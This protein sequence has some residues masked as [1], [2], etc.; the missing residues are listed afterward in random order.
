MT[1]LCPAWGGGTVGFR[2]GRRA[3]LWRPRAQEAPRADLSQ[4]S[5]SGARYHALAPYRDQAIL[6][7]HALHQSARFERGWKLLSGTYKRTVVIPEV[8]V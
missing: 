3:R 8:Y 1:P 7:L 4:I 6:T 2:G 5:A